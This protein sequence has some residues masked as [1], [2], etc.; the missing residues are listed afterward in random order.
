MKSYPKT[1]CIV[2]PFPPPFGGMAIQAEK[3]A[4]HLER[5][6]F[7]IIRIKTNPDLPQAL[8]WVL[9]IPVFR[10]L[11][12]TVFFLCTLHKA[13]LKSDAVYFMTA[14]PNFFLWVTYPALILIR[15]HGKKIILSARGG[16]AEPFFKTYKAL[17]RPILLKTDLI[18]APS[19]FLRDV[20]KKYFDIEP[21]IIPTIADFS[22][23]FFR[24]RESFRPLLLATRNL[25]EIYDIACIIRAFK[26]VHDRFPDARL[27]IVGDGSLRNE[28][29]SLASSLG[30]SQR[31]IFYGAM[32]HKKIQAIYDQ[33][34]IAVN[35]SRI[36]N[37]P[38]TILEAFATGLPVVSTDAGGIPYIVENGVTGLLVSVGDH[39]ALAENVIR[40]VET[41][42]LG[43]SLAKAGIQHCQSYSWEHVKKILIPLLMQMA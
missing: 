29:E 39:K 16:A 15:L 41:P 28:L 23:F 14:F 12:N 4:T 38:G 32:N 35:A 9:K 33:Y 6:G 26:M 20:F 17:I 37:L 27:G 8:K 3:T 7:E 11:V 24:E 10:T 30:L 5:E 2:S 19:G 22:Q 31:I 1:I 40:I 13:L 43:K 21:V 36:D 34:D 25:E 42:E 18:A